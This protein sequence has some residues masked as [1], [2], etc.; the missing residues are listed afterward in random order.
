LRAAQRNTKS[1]GIVGESISVRLDLRLANHRWVGQPVTNMNLD[2]LN[3]LLGA[4][5][6]GLL[7]QDILREFHSVRIDYRNHLIE[8][9]E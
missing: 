4:Q 6:D 2:D 9:E 5:F 1:A 8:L 3:R 7:G